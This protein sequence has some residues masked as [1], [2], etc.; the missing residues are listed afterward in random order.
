MRSKGSTSLKPEN[1]NLPRKKRK[2]MLPK[3]PKKSP[4]F[5]D[6]FR[7][8]SSSER[9]PSSS[10]SKSNDS[11][12]SSTGSQSSLP[13]E[14]SGKSSRSRKSS[15]G[16]SSSSRRRG[17]RGPAKPLTAALLASRSLAAP[18]THHEGG[19]KVHSS[20]LLFLHYLR[21]LYNMDLVPDKNEFN[22]LMMLV[23]AE[24]ADNTSHAGMRDYPKPIDSATG[25]AGKVAQPSGARFPKTSIQ[26]KILTGGLS[27]LERCA[28]KYLETGGGRF[29]SALNLASGGKRSKKRARGP[30]KALKVILN[31]YRLYDNKLRAEVRHLPAASLHGVSLPTD[32]NDA[33]YACGVLKKHDRKEGT[34]AVPKILSMHATIK[35]LFKYAKRVGVD[36]AKCVPPPAD[37]A[38]KRDVSPKELAAMLNCVHSPKKKRAGGDDAKKEHSEHA[39]ILQNLNQA[40][41]LL[42]E[43]KRSFTAADSLVSFLEETVVKILGM[44]QNFCRSRVGVD[45]C[46]I[47]APSEH[48]CKLSIRHSRLPSESKKDLIENYKAAGGS[49]AQNATH[50]DHV[51]LKNGEVAKRS[52]SFFSS[53]SSHG[54]AH[55]KPHS[56]DHGSRQSS[57]GSGSNGSSA[58]SSNSGHRS[59]QR[60][61]SSSTPRSALERLR[62]NRRDKSRPPPK[63]SKGSTSSSESEQPN[64]KK[65]KHT[66]TTSSSSSEPS[67]SDTDTASDGSLPPFKAP[68]SQDGSSISG[69]P[70]SSTSSEK[71]ER[72]RVTHPFRGTGSMKSEKPTSA[73][74]SGIP[75]GAAKAQASSARKTPISAWPAMWKKSLPKSSVPL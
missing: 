41:H 45:K 34:V 3:H 53:H 74:K 48:A 23:V 43:Q 70:T 2:D 1:Y 26:S 67:A 20:L 68:K 44:M 36:V 33:R 51:R 31:D 6:R 5:F 14:S 59:S 42:Q 25:V 66:P 60:N 35:K 49:D 17:P 16:S 46:D 12:S 18:S 27:A 10:S 15:S 8:R 64:P 11:R 73:I 19:D 57:A 69:T 7:K 61:S 75:G 9:S 30:G 32:L 62:A 21:S 54:S 55:E 4:G 38:F 29:S 72:P 65:P 71:K 40:V 47:S 63:P 52:A 22:K 24:V 50:L 39:G 28:T 58:G 56:L 37:Y 13:S